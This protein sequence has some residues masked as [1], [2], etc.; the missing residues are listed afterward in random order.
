MVSISNNYSDI[1]SKN[2]TYNNDITSFSNINKINQDF[3]NKNY[4]EIISSLE[5]E[6]E[7]LKQDLEKKN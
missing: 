3:Q 2:E 5:K 1:N 6:N 4:Q 7:T